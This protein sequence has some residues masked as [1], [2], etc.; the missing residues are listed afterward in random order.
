MGTYNS[1]KKYTGA[2]RRSRSDALFGETGKDDDDGDDDGADNDD[3]DN[4]ADDDG[5][6][7]PA[8][9]C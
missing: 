4:D 7:P 2:W 8:R 1:A 6:P 5:D 9:R 3:D